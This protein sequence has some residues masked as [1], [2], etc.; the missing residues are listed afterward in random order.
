MFLKCMIKDK[1][2]GPKHDIFALYTMSQYADDN[3]EV[4]QQ[5]SNPEKSK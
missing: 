2:L 5:G 3:N 1:Y 4:G